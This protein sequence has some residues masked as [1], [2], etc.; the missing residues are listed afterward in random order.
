MKGND[1]TKQRHQVNGMVDSALLLFVPFHNA[2]LLQTTTEGILEYFI[3]DCPLGKFDLSNI[4]GFKQV[5]PAQ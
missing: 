4:R 3:F 2:S 5:H 1:I